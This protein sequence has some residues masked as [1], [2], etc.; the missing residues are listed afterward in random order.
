MPEYK[1][2]EYMGGTV[3]AVTDP[4][5]LVQHITEAGEYFDYLKDAWKDYEAAE[6]DFFAVPV[7]DEKIIA[8][9]KR[10][11]R[12][13]RILIGYAGTMFDLYRDD[14]E[15]RR[16]IL[17]IYDRFSKDMAVIRQN[18]SKYRDILN[19]A[20]APEPAAVKRAEDAKI[21]SSRSML[22]ALNTQ[23]RVRKLYENGESFSCAE[24][25][26]E[27]GCAERSEKLFS[28]LPDVGIYKPAWIYPPVAFPEGTRVPDPPEAYERVEDLPAED[29]VYDKSLDEIVVRPGYISEDGLI[30]DRSVVWHPENNT[31]TIR[32]RGGEPVIW[33]YWK[34]KDPSDV[35]E[36]DSWPARYILR[37]FRQVLD[38]LEVKIFDPAR[39]AVLDEKFWKRL[40]Q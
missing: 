38:D 15:K 14:P 5:G 13:G 3:R 2:V 27:R 19:A 7:S 10:W 39:T 26:L 28:K 35:P 24:A 29:L 32:F 18:I 25:E 33:S 31:V 17:D 37:Y 9:G 36:R 40:A 8:A 21:E 1:E 11:E 23:I 4:E 6:A 34:P 12:F 30:D 20:E 16:M 22:R